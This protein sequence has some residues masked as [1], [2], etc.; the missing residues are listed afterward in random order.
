[1]TGKYTK[2]N[3]VYA[4]AIYEWQGTRDILQFHALFEEWVK[5]IGMPPDD[6][7]LH[8]GGEGWKGKDYKYK[9]FVRRD[10]IHRQKWKDLSYHWR[11]EPSARLY[12]AAW[13]S[14]SMGISPEVTIVIDEAAVPDISS[15]FEVLT[16]FACEA[17]LPVYGIGLAVPY[18][19]SPVSFI[20]GGGSGYVGP[21]EGI[22]YDSRG[23]FDL[24]GMAAGHL[25]VAKP[26]VLDHKML[27]IFA[28]N[29]ISER[30]LATP[31]HG[32]PLKVW[33]EQ[34]GLGTLKQVSPVTWRW[35]V[36]RN[37]QPAVRRVA[38]EAG[39]IADPF[40]TKL[41]WIDS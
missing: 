12:Q 25:L 28:I 32:V 38:I 15:M 37:Q 18:S 41:G 17:L 7:W 3:V 5:L 8:D 29:L 40:W 14:V 39:L 22:R 16:G 9:T 33:I 2:D 31:V 27:D 23:A 19:W 26:R 21:E 13:F 34:Q 36:P 30:H 1:M 4:L 20:T 24:R 10:I 35:D 6:V 11:R